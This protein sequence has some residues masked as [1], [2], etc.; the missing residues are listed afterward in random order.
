MDKDKNRID[1]IAA[2]RKKVGFLISGYHF[3]NVCLLLFLLVY[4]L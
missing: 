2:G 3:Y 1:L 4:V